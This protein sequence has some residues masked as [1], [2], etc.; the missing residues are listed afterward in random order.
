M[1][2]N[3]PCYYNVY[4]IPPAADIVALRRCRL[5]HRRLITE[6]YAE[7]ANFEATNNLRKA[8]AVR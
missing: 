8:L 6:L 1:F 4:F 5:A 2:D 3:G 7:P